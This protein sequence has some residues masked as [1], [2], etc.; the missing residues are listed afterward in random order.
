MLYVLSFSLLTSIS[1]MLVD[2]GVTEYDFVTALAEI[3]DN[4]IEAMLETNETPALSIKYEGDAQKNYIIIR[5]N[6]KG[7]LRDDVIKWGTLGLNSK[8]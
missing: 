8:Q 1:E 5:D 2:G 3:I 4:S 6:G 7:M